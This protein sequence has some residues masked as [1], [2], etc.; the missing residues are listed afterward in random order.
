MTLKT[1]L[2]G[3][4]LRPAYEIMLTFLR[5]PRVSDYII[6]PKKSGARRIVSTGSNFMLDFPRYRPIYRGSPIQPSTRLT[7]LSNRPILIKPHVHSTLPRVYGYTIKNKFD[8]QSN[9][10]VYI[11]KV[12]LLT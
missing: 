9:C 10:A 4:E 7:L 12:V 8:S 1:M 11:Y 3:W 5:L 2:R 6:T